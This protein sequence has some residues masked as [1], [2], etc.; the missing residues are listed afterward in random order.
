MVESIKDP[1]H[2]P[3]DMAKELGQI[4]VVNYTQAVGTGGPFNAI[5]VDLPGQ[6]T[7][8]LQT[9]LLRS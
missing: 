5:N 7:E 3:Y 8:Q 6:L 1:L 2:V 9:I 4:H